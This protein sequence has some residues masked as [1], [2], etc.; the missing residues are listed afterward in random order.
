[1]L[2]KNADILLALMLMERF[3]IT[4]NFRRTLS[5]RFLIVVSPKQIRC[6]TAKAKGLILAYCMNVL[7]VWAVGVGCYNFQAPCGCYAVII[8]SFGRN[9]YG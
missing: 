7:N 2:T 5:I 8:R 4:A 6:G 3:G 9:F 1:M